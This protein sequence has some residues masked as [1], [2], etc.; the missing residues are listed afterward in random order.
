MLTAVVLLLLG[1]LIDG[2]C[3]E[4]L[5]HADGIFIFFNVAWV[6]QIS[7]DTRIVE[8]PLITSIEGICTRCHRRVP[9]MHDLINGWCGENTSVTNPMATSRL[10]DVSLV[11]VAF[12]FAQWIYKRRSSCC[13]LANYRSTVA[14]HRCQQGLKIW[15]VE[16]GSF[17][18]L[19]QLQWFR[20]QYMRLHFFDENIIVELDN[21][22]FSHYFVFRIY[23]DLHV[24]PRDTVGLANIYLP[25]TWFLEAIFMNLLVTVDDINK[26][27]IVL[28]WYSDWLVS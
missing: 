22:E 25:T 2:N 19:I 5:G 8:M 28:A 3:W 11:N 21:I 4:F 1:K 16:H 26:F 7:I 20:L 10:I 23:R 27:D 14:A 13:K 15:L 24:D 18:A 17:R 9:P 6:V 12:V